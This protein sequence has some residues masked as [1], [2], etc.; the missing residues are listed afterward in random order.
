MS[1]T[2]PDS[3]RSRRRSSPLGVAMSERNTQDRE[4]P[5]QRPDG[6]LIFGRWGVAHPPDVE[7]P[8]AVFRV[9]EWG[10]AQANRSEIGPC[11]HPSRLDP[12]F[13]AADRP[14]SAY[15]PS[16]PAPDDQS[17][18]AAPPP[19]ALQPS[20]GLLFDRRGWPH[21]RPALTLPPPHG[22]VSGATHVTQAPRIGG[23]RA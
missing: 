1:A 22:N 10:V 5:G 17:L 4:T 12:P 9:L 7:R 19:E 23:V 14:P 20:S 6:G 8:E 16:L 13:V 3:N 2:K 21:F 11:A 15:R 18:G